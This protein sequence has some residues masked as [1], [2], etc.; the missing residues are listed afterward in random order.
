[1]Y[2]VVFKGAL[3]VSRG[4]RKIVYLISLKYYILTNLNG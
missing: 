1:M 4:N 3:S 2:F